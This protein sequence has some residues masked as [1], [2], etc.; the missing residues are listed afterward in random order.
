[1][2]L[3]FIGGYYIIKGDWNKLEPITYVIGIV[4]LA[5]EILCM[6]VLGKAFN[7]MHCLENFSEY[8]YKK[9]CAKYGVTK[10]TIE[11]LKC[12]IEEKKALLKNYEEVQ[13]N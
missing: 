7:P 6:M 11:G 13:R 3:F 9:E 12:N 4:P 10:T 5:L 1:M 2:Q 8:R